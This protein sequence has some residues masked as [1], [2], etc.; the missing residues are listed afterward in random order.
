[1]NQGAAA[2]VAQDCEMRGAFRWPASDMPSSEAPRT[3]Q[4]STGGLAWW[5]EGQSLAL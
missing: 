1:M 3:L 5:Q 4:R 2:R